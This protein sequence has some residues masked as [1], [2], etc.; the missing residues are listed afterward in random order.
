V[1]DPAFTDKR[2]FS[3]SC[4]M[5]NSWMKK[6]EPGR[7]AIPDEKKAVRKVRQVTTLKMIEVR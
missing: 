5:E 6:K 3:L 7:I 2:F 1:D 4:Q